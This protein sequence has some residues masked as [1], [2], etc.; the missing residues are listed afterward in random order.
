VSALTWIAVALIGGLAA[1]LRVTADSFSAHHL[2]RSLRSPGPGARLAAGTFAVNVTGS[3]LLGLVDG[4]ALSGNASI[5]IGTA[6]IGTYTTFSAWMLQTQVLRSDGA[7]LAA[8]VLVV[9]S[10]VA[11]FGAVALGR[12]IGAG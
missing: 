4:L 12:L 8:T 1:L 7:R 6:G 9:A 10:L 3:L 2:L 5:V 11:G